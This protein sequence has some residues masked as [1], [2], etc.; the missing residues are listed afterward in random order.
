M[1][2]D[3]VKQDIHYRIATKKELNGKIFLYIGNCPI[4]KIIIEVRDELRP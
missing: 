4:G 2:I 3:S 1:W